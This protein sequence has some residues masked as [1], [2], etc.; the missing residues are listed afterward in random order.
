VLPGFSFPVA[1]FAFFGPAGLPQPIVSRLNAEIGKALAAPDVR[2]KNKELFSA[3][4][5]S[6]PEQFVAFL[7]RADESYASLAKSG[8]I[9]P[10]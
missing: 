4:I 10:Q 5:F 8:A 3:E 6:P 9:Q 2:A 7:H 1:F